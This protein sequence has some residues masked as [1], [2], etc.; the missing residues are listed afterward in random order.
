MS[1]GK[2]V[3]QSAVHVEC[4]EQWLHLWVLILQKWGH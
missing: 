1:F 2:G 4:C 3:A